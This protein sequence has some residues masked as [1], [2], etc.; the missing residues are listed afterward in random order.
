[1][2]IHELP[3]PALILDVDVFYE[4]I[5][6]AN[7]MLNGS[8]MKLRPHYKSCKCTALAHMQLARGA[9]GITCSKLEE[10]KDLILAGVEDVLIANQITNKQKI[11]ELAALARCCKLTVCVDQAENIADLQAAAKL[12][13][14]VIHCYIEYDIGMKRCGVYT[15][16]EFDA[17]AQKIRACSNLSFDGIQA[18]AGN[19]SHEENYQKR[20]FSSQKVEERLSELLAYMEGRGV[21]IK[22]VSGTSTGTIAFRGRDSVYTEIQAGSYVYMDAAYRKLNPGFD[23]S[24]FVLAE[25]ISKSEGQT[26][27]DAGVKGIST[28]QTA[29]LLADYPEVA[30]RVSEEHCTIHDKA[31]ASFKIG[32]RCK[33]IPGHCCTTMNLYDRIFLVKGE[34]VMDCIP[35]TGRGKSR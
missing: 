24:L 10:A 29:P 8:K 9:K 30:F 19:L 16:E 2:N 4:N 12:Q 23:H 1:M 7:A 27:L 15:K 5:E 17:L 35:V 25:V 14:S 28:D 32:D 31:L 13:D 18:Y 3:T 33:L 22:E 34:K 21:E 11:A 26:I 20:Q 6:K